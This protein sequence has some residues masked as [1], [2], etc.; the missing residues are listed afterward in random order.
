MERR[1]FLRKAGGAL[2]V[3]ASSS[4][5]GCYSIFYGNQDRMSGFSSTTG[6][7]SPKQATTVAKTAGQ[8]VSALLNEGATIWIPGDAKIDMSD[9]SGLYI[10]DGV[11]IASNRGLNGAGGLITYSS[12]GKDL[13]VASPKKLRVSGLRFQGPRTDFYDPGEQ[14]AIHDNTQCFDLMGG[15]VIIDNC[16][17]YGWQKAALHFQTDENIRSWI[18]HNYIHHNQMQHR[19][20]GIDLI[21]GQHLIEWNTFNANRHAITGSGFPSCGYEAR[22]NVQGPKT[23]YQVFDM[24]S[25]AEVQPGN[26]DPPLA[27]KYVRIHHNVSFTERSVTVGIRGVP[28]EKSVVAN[29]WFRDVPSSRDVPMNVIQQQIDRT[30]TD[31]VHLAQYRDL[32]VKG[33]SFGE[34]AAQNG[35]Q[36]LKQAASKARSNG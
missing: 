35:L 10:A 29:N 26:Y 33:N 14:G 6:R 16:E 12:T 28:R 15:P 36:T 11:T 24:H 22:F 18:H 20:Y 31:I 4:L 17:F 23:V 9:Y 32:T 3:A 13:F 19:G 8:L 5:S 30:P 1:D 25:A 27:G 34:R 21:T 7:V 2:G